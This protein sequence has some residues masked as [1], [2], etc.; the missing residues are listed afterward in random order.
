MSSDPEILLETQGKNIIDRGTRQKTSQIWE[1]QPGSKPPGYIVVPSELAAWL[2]VHNKYSLAMNRN[3]ECRQHQGLA[4]AGKFF[5]RDWKPKVEHR[6]PWDVS[7]WVRMGVND[8]L[9]SPD[10]IQASFS[11]L[12]RHKLSQVELER[13]RAQRISKNLIPCSWEYRS[14]WTKE[15][16]FFMHI[17]LQVYLYIFRLISTTKHTNHNQPSCLRTC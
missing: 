17:H 16:V 14:V 10:C 11:D 7:E 6:K 12:S 4:I 8:S 2:S 5:H 3:H 15:N 1:Q 13:R 9:L